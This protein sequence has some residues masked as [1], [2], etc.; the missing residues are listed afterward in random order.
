MEANT[1]ANGSDAQAILDCISDGVLTIDLDKRVRYI[2]RAMRRML[3]YEDSLPTNLL[4]CDVIVQSNICGTSDCVLEQALRGERVSHYEAFMRRRDGGLVPISINTDFL[5]DDR[6][7]LIGLIEVIRDISIPKELTER[8]AE[9]TA[10]RERLGEQTKFENMIGRSRRMREIFSVLRV[11]AHSKTS[12]LI[13]GESGTGKELIASAVHANSPRKDKPFVVVNCSALSEGI[14]ESELFGHV[15]G[16]FT[17]AFYDKMGRFEIANDGTIFLDEI[18]EIS[19]A[20]QVKLLRVLENE[21]FERVGDSTTIRVDVRVVAATNR[22]LAQA[23]RDGTFREDLYYRIRVFPIDLPPLRERREDIP[24]LV[25]YFVE[26]FNQELGRQVQQ[27]APEALNFLE[28]YSYPG[29]IRELHNIIEHAFVCCEDHVIR[30]HHL[31]TDIQKCPL[32]VPGERER[33]N[34]LKRLEHET[35]VRI[36]DQSGWRYKTASERLGISR[37]TLWRKLKRIR[38]SASKDVSV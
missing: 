31:P 36:L 35:I 29:N 20:T 16:A 22:N 8:E 23:V 2:N 9:V 11:V 26:Q 28:N 38:Q 33:M 4:A 24:L 18:G 10:L 19:M 30:L 6:G 34:S 13:T 5:R 3:G 32:G 15:K 25:K 7:T 14:L 37:S 27:V 12:V 17:G 21:E 1:H